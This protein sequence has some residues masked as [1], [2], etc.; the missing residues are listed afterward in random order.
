[1]LC[2]TLLYVLCHTEM[3]I[4]IHL[5]ECLPGLGLLGWARVNTRVESYGVDV[6][7]PAQPSPAQTDTVPFPHKI[8]V[9]TNTL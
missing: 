4:M 7:S 5:N 8:A 1:M 2:C 6:P 9:I 3:Q